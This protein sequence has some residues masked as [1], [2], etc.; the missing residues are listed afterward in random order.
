[1]KHKII[2]A[3]GVPEE[4]FHEDALRMMRAL[5]FAAVLD[6]NLESA[7]FEAICNQ[8]ER[9]ENVS[10]E[11]IKMEMDKLFLGSNPMAAFQLFKET[12]LHKAVP[13]Y[14]EKML[15]VESALPFASVKEG[16]AFFLVAGGYSASALS[17]A[18]K[19]S[20]E[21]KR[22]IAEVE[23]AYAI[24][25]E[26]P[27]TVDE[28]YI[29]DVP[30]LEA[31]EKFYRARAMD[32]S[33][34]SFPQFKEEKNKLPIQSPRDLQVNGKDLLKWADVK[35]GRWTGEW[36]KR[37]EAAVLHGRCENDPNKIREWFMNDFNSK[38]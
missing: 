20:N 19:L 32:R 4:R 14:P 25:K 36:M 37:I 33:F 17:Q 6:F 30:V 27:F 21:E 7:T 29:Y 10:V 38:K 1:M 26:R 12:G 34:A 15:G 3:V 28:L 11:R 9:L 23:T 18:Y 16:W 22:F 31:A 13:L 2:R 5:R 24:R 8:A 35:G